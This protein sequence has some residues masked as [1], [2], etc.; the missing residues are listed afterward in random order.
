MA[1][2]KIDD[3]FIKTRF[4]LQFR[5]IKRVGQTADIQNK[6]RLRWDAELEAEG[7]DCQTHGALRAA[8]LVEQVADA[9]FVLRSREQA[10]IDGVVRPVFEGL[11]DPALPAE[12]FPGGKTVRNAHR[13]AA[14][15]LTVAAHQHIVRGIKEQDLIFYPLRVQLR[16]SFFDFFRRAAAADVHTESHPLELVVT[17]FRKRRDAGQQ[18]RRDVINAEKADVFQCIHGDRFACTGKAADDEKIHFA[19]LFLL[20]FHHTNFFFEVVAGLFFHDDTH[21]IAQSQHI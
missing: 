15:R 18:C 10:G 9:L 6:I 1:H 5:D 14:A 3:L 20:C 11:Q 12:G 4:M 8:V 19:R 17:R 16:K 2:D 21:L 13:M 7:H